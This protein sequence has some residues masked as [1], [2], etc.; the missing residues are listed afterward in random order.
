MSGAFDMN[1]G[2][3]VS[4]FGVTHTPKSTV[5]HYNKQANSFSSYVSKSKRMT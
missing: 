2:V 3:N 4:K 1:V 5:Q